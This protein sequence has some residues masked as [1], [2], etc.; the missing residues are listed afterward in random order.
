MV[1]VF[2]NI[3]DVQNP[4]YRDIDDVL[5]DIKNGAAKKS[6]E[7][8]RVTTDKERRNKL[9][10]GLKSICFSG[11]FSYRSAR[12]CIK[13][14]G[15]ACLDFDDVDDPEKLR[16]DLRENEYIYSAFVSPSGNGVKAIFKI[17][18]EIKDHTK[19]YEAIC[20]TFD[21][22]LDTKTKD[23]TRVCYE[24]FD[25]DLWFNK[26]SKLWALKKEYTEVTKNSNYPT[27][28]QI[29]DVSKKVD[30]I[31]KW[32]N[33]KF[34]LGAGERNNNL[35]RLACGLNKA[36]QSKSE[37]QSM[38]LNIYSSG[39][40]ES[41][42]NLII[43]S[44]YRNT[45][46]F[47][48]LTLVDDAKIYEA[49]RILKKGVARAK[50]E[51]RKS[52]ISEGDIDDILD[53]DFEDDYLVFWDT[54][55]NGKISLNDYKFKLFLENRGFYKVQLNEK[56]F[57]FVK[58][59]NNIISEV[60][61]INIKDFV[62][63]HVVEVDMLV[64]NFFAKSTSKFTE[65]YLTLLD[66]KE[67][68]MIRDDESNSYLFYQNTV[69]HITVDAVEFIKYINIGGFVWKKNI[70]PHDFAVTDK[71]SDFET[72]IG[73][74][75]KKEDKRKEVIECAIGY[76]LNNFKKD[77]EG[78]AIIFYD[79]TLNDNPSGRT[80]KT[81]ISK[82]LS[83]MRKLVTLNGK[84]FDNKGQ[85]PYQTINL[86]DNIICFDDMDRTFKFESLFSIITGNLTLNKKNLQPIEIP[87]EESPKILFTSNYI[88]S[89]VGDSHD[90][91][92]VEIELYRHYSKNYKPVDEFKKMFFR[93]WNE[94]EWN[95]FFNY[96]ISNIQ[97]YLGKGILRSEL[98]TGKTKKL[99]AN[100]CE[101]FYMFCENEFFWKE[102]HPYTTKE[103]MSSY[104]DGKNEYPKSMNSSWFGRWIGMY[105]DFK[106]WERD[107]FMHLGQRKF[108]ITGMNT[109]DKLKSEGEE[110]DVPF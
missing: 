79:E 8:I 88:L 99:I 60:N 18:A 21:T 19:Y 74:V 62:L 29:T 1:T 70:I 34:T 90:A 41:E 73:N 49:E 2:A 78:L 53:F 101:D 22:E 45:T 85:F 75:S 83:E 7:E 104:N 14:S 44:A 92:K 106:K 15:Y 103:I 89:G 51:F 55:K 107:P 96:M 93:G 16:E 95:A 76:L 20:E 39:L 36:G 47:D 10:Q 43:D 24:S 80:G 97:Q 30:V 102:D 66:T 63:N 58:V 52:G 25:A 86:D 11:E 109:A 105:A 77:D 100:T 64:Y 61:E 48:T 59:Y 33:K 26:E 42:L 57:T 94:E 68:A 84:E 56:E 23:I 82:A 67:L 65:N 5:N 3:R 17:P 87:F 72:F 13:H 110:N 32:F 50:R 12:N 108:R 91:R 98:I 27:H 71:K 6:V 31:L 37:T 35:Y 69:V 28:F 46:E 81:L 4:F 9:K 40:K 54:D 38:F